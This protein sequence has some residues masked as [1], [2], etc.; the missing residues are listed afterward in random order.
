MAARPSQRRLRGA[1]LRHGPTDATLP[2]PRNVR[3]HARRL[4]RVGVES[5]DG[6]DERDKR[7][8]DLKQHDP[9][10]AA[11]QAEAAAREAKTVYAMAVERGVTPMVIER[12]RAKAACEDGGGAMAIA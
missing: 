1:S 6:R 9:R 3:A 10:A 2:V 4:L 5:C 8:E 7:A 12:E 11:A